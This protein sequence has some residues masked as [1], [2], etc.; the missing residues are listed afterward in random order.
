MLFF[1]NLFPGLS[2]QYIFT[3]SYFHDAGVVKINNATMLSPI[4]NLEEMLFP[5]WKSFSTL[6]I[7]WN[8]DIGSFGNYPTLEI[9]I[10]KKK[11]LS[12]F[13]CYKTGEFNIYEK[14]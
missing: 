12:R 8:L 4:V 2:Q 14:L 5:A 10:F 13:F 1:P 7:G 11:L 3:A 9:Q 6:T